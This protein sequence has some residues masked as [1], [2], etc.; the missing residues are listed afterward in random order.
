[1]YLKEMGSKVIRCRFEII[2]SLSET[3]N[4]IQEVSFLKKIKNKNEKEKSTTYYFLIGVP[5]AN[6][7]FKTS[8]YNK[9]IKGKKKTT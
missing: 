8:I 6:F 2:R 9:K 7:C 3:C 1:M 4:T 5:A